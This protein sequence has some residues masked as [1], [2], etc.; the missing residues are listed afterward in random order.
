MNGDRHD[1]SVGPSTQNVRETDTYDT[2]IIQAMPE[3]KVI[4]GLI[5]YYFQYCQ[6]I[7]RHIWEATFRTQWTR[8]KAGDNPDT[9]VLA[10]CCGILAMTTCVHDVLDRH[11]PTLMV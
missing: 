6:W 3:L 4:D 2:D 1:G 10:T 5:D 7:N 11:D 9:L 8:Y